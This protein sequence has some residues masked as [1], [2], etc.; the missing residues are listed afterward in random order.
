MNLEPCERPFL[1]TLRRDAFILP[2]LYIINACSIAKPYALEQ[3]YAE[4]KSY[5]LDVA[6]V[7]ETHLKKHHLE[8]AIQINGYRLYRRDRLGRRAG[9]VAVLVAEALRASEQEVTGYTRTLELLWVKVTLPGRTVFVGA[10]YHPPR[11]VYDTE[12]L[13]TRLE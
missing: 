7:T 12:I 1:L 3:L 8:K 10:L 11:P 6:I 2:G 5:E 13:L 9:G 4:M